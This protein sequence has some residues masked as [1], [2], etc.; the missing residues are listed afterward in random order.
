MGYEY[1]DIALTDD[2]DLVI[3]TD[4]LE[5]G[6]NVG[7]DFMTTSRVSR[8]RRRLKLSSVGSAT[9][10]GYGSL[11][12]QYLEALRAAYP[13]ETDDILRG[14][15]SDWGNRPDDNYEAIRQN[16]RNR[17]KTS[18]PDWEIYPTIGAD[19]E[20]SIG[21]DIDVFSCEDLRQRVFTTLTKDGMI[22][23]SDLNVRYVRVEQDVIL[24]VV[25]VTGL[26]GGP[27][28]TEV[29]PFSFIDGPI[30]VAKGALRGNSI[31]S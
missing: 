19:L 11:M 10:P 26:F 2:G 7:W 12:E 1:E 24:I 27:I 30:I 31:Y 4:P 28:I 23:T 6:V 25:Q 29:F 17:I 20:L 18:N 22:D 14:Y 5:A 16:I 13:G 21:M 15:I 3:D 9:V 8:N